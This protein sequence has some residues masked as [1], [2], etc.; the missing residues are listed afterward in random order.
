MGCDF[1]LNAEITGVIYCADDGGFWPDKTIYF[2]GVADTD[3][4][5]D[6]SE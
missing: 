6:N 1:K 5:A 3:K 4:K 2:Y